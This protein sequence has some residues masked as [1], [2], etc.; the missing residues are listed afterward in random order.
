MTTD[1][2]N[3]TPVSAARPRWLAALPVAVV[4]A[5]LVALVAL[6][7][8]GPLAG[9]LEHTISV[10]ENAYQRWFNQ[11]DTTNPAL[12]IPLA[13]GGG[14]VASLSPCILALLPLNLTYIGTRGITS[15]RDAFF[16]AGAFVLGAVTVLSL[17][18]LFSGFASAVVVDYKG[19]IHAAVG[20]L[21]VVMGLGLLGVIR[22]PLPQ[23]NLK[24]P[25]GPFGVGFTFALVSSPC[26]SPVLIAVL[27]AA[28]ATGSPLL[29]ALAMVSYALG[30]TAV[31]FLASLFAG[32]ASRTRLL[33]DHSETIVR[34]GAALLVATGGYYLWSGLSWFGFAIS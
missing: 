12:L 17:F 10:T 34:F 27:L 29:G 7:T 2:P 25:A 18:G 24:V 14:L 16:K 33:L 3:A 4:L 5:A 28:G 20:V 31:I 13:F 26:A 15:R 22:L 9:V 11:Q 21:I 1:R 19:Y 8:V 30:Y 23:V 32:L 6:V